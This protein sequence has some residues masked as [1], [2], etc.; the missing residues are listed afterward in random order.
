MKAYPLVSVCIITYNQ[1]SYITQTIEGVLMQQTKF[2]FEIIISDDCSTDGTREIC[3]RY[4]KFNPD[5]V[6]LMLPSKNQGISRN[7][8]N[9]LFNA[10]GKYIAFCEGDDYW[11]DPY[12]LQKQ[13]DYLELN[14]DVGCVYTDFNRLRQESGYIEYSLF[15]TNS[16]W[17]PLHSDLATFIC[18]PSYFAPCTWMF[19]KE[20]LV[21]PPFESVDSTFVLFAHMLSK[22]A[23]YFLPDTTSVYRNLPESAS[24]SLSLYKTYI[25]ISGLYET[26]MKLAKLY[27]LSDVLKQQISEKY[28]LSNLKLIAAFGNENAIYDM[29]QVL[30]CMR[31]KNVQYLQ[32]S[33][34][35]TLLG[36]KILK[37]WCKFRFYK[38]GHL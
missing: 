13:V 38:Y 23:I 26:Q 11:I 33:L 29:N 28:Y 17:F 31:L 15:R 7:F 10:L 16:Q 2:P 36:R 22:T 9:T 20:L 30:K 1:S 4:S 25:R 6:R 19:R 18:N 5:K 24:H 8:Y 34:S 14:P 35:H 32:L 12:K 27:G 37:M 3:K 21:K